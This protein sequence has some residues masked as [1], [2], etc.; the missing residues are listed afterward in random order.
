MYTVEQLEKTLTN[1]IYAITGMVNEDLVIK[2]GVLS[3]KELGAERYVKLVVENLKDIF[4]YNEEK[5]T[6][7]LSIQLDDKGKKMW[8]DLSTKR[9]MRTHTN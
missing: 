7:Y 4:A 9:R 2:S 5:G 8:S 6:I 1:P 3:I